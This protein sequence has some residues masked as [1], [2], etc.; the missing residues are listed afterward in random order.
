M[1]NAGQWPG[2]AIADIGG[3]TGDGACGG[4]AAEQGCRQIGDTLAD[5]FL[6]GVV[7]GP[8]HTIRHHRGE[9]RFDGAQHGNGEGRAD[10]LDDA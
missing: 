4:E 10:Q 5:Q 8:G 2:G 1:G 9:Q 7:L 6:I 3:G